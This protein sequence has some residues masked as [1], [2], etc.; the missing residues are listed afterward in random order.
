MNSRP[1]IAFISFALILFVGSRISRLTPVSQNTSKV[2]TQLCPVVDGWSAR[3]Q[4]SELFSAVRSAAGQHGVDHLLL[5]AVIAAESGCKKQA[6][7]HRGALGMMQLMPTTATWLGVEDPMSV[8]E[9]INGGAKYLAYLLRRFN[10]N[11]KLALAAYNAGPE[12]VK[13]AR[14][15]PP[16]K[17]TQRYVIKVLDFYQQLR[18]GSTKALAI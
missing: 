11:L 18:N 4:R 6:V 15:V 17:E 10:N 12:K 1:L 9:N 8:H 5:L 16:Y 7:S 14:G 2:I 3:R 13:Q